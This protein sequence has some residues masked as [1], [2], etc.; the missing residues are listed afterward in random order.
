MSNDDD[1]KAAE[2]WATTRTSG[3][4][5]DF[6]KMGKDGYPT[7]ES[8]SRELYIEIATRAF[9]QGV[10]HERKRLERRFKENAEWLMQIHPIVEQVGEKH[11]RIKE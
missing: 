9:C 1:R 11:W 2:E 8:I 7:S 6:A 4:K 5:L 3:Y 10:E